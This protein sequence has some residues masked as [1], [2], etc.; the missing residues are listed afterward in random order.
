[1]MAHAAQAPLLEL[2]AELPH[3][4]VFEHDFLSASEE[5]ALLEWFATLPLREARFKTYYARRRVVSFHSAAFGETYDSASDDDLAPVGPPPPLIDGLRER[6]AAFVG[7]HGHPTPCTSE[8]FVHV[9]VSEYQA[10]TPI[11]WHRDKP[12]Y[13]IV[14]GISLGS[15]ARMRFRPVPAPG[16]WTRV[17]PKSLIVLDLEP[18]SIYLMRGEI[19]SRW[20]HSI[21][22]TKALRYSITMRTLAADP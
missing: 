11:G 8:S 3:G 5:S 22:P 7:N 17:D 15:R 14:A 20:Q 6:V 12:Q 13:G 2:P 16:E 19:R 9:L 10:G 1:M 4:L 18:R 21:L